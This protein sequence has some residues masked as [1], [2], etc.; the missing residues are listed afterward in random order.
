MVLETAAAAIFLKGKICFKMLALNLGKTRS[1][2]FN[3]HY[4]SFLK[5][6]LW[7][8]SLAKAISLPKGIHQIIQLYLS[9]E[10]LGSL[11]VSLQRAVHPIV[12]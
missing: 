8:C 5:G 2:I 7:S 6:K 10:V 1:L 12:I 4:C 9:F 3:Y 11:Q